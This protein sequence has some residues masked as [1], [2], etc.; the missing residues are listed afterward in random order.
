MRPDE[1]FLRDIA[2]NAQ[3]LPDSLT[4]KESKQILI[5]YAL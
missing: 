4:L 1:S 3:L 5:Q 2:R